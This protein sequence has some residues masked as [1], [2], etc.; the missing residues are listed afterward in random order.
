MSNPGFAKTWSTETG[1]GW[2]MTS[3]AVS[4][5]DKTVTEKWVKEKQP[6][7]RKVQKPTGKSHEKKPTGAPNLKTGTVRKRPATK[8]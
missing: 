8:S 1:T 2:K 5:P 4:I 7:A 3:I 6:A